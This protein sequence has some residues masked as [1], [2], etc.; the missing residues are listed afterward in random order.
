M[1]V[2]QAFAYSAQ[3]FKDGIRS[4]QILVGESPAGQDDLASCNVSVNLVLRLLFSQCSGCGDAHPCVSVELH[5]ALDLVQC[6]RL[7]LLPTTLRHPNVC[8][9]VFVT[10]PPVREVWC[11]SSCSTKYFAPKR[12]SCLKSKLS[13]LLA[14]LACHVASTCKWLPPVTDGAVTD[15]F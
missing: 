2:I 12:K 13:W 1:I 4:S 5:T 3:D 8:T 7:L 14:C 15:D 6:F 9:V 11:A 10:P